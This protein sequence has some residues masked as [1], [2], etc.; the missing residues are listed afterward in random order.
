MLE[1]NL[2]NRAASQSTLSFNSMFRVGDVYLGANENGLYRMC[3]GSSD[4][5]VEINAVIK[6]GNTDFGSDRIKRARFFYLGVECQGD[7]ELTL[8]CDG[9][10]KHTYTVL[11]GSASGNKMVKVPI[12]KDHEGVYWSWMVKNKDGCLFKIRSVG[13]TYILK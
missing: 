11:C 10:E 9:V 6:T 4:N 12:S 8:F 5:G 13:W 7:L 3:C 1:L 2:A